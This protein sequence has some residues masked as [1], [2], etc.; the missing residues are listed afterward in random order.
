[1]LRRKCA[2]EVGEQGLGARGG[3]GF[4]LIVSHLS[5]GSPE[6]CRA[7]VVSSGE[8]TSEVP[9]HSGKVSPGALGSQGEHSFRVHPSSSRG[10]HT[11]V[12]MVE[13]MA[14]ESQ[15][16]KKSFRG[17]SRASRPARGLWR[18]AAAHSASESPATKGIENMSPYCSWS[19]DGHDAKV[20]LPGIF[21]FL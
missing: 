19:N 4:K 3:S 5:A 18:L 14:Q 8:R 16:E 13:E 20:F 2:N 12:S 7:L 10:T 11:C 17:Q 9:C 6:P 21:F 1:M 15:A